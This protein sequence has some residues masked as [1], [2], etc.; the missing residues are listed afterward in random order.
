MCLCYLPVLHAREGMHLD[1]SCCQRVFFFCVTAFA[2]GHHSFVAR[3][4][5]RCGWGR[6]SASQAPHAHEGANLDHSCRQR[7]CGVNLCNQ[8]LSRTM[9]IKGNSA[10]LKERIWI[11]RVTNE[12]VFLTVA[13]LCTKCMSLQCER[14]RF[15]I[16]KS[17]CEMSQTVALE[18]PGDVVSPIFQECGLKLR[19]NWSTRCSLLFGRDSTHRPVR[20]REVGYIE[21]KRSS[22]EVCITLHH[23]VKHGRLFVAICR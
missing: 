13:L 11:Y 6:T 10:I 16:L 18:N 23:G 14:R 9:G 8:P 7:A 22:M 20:T 15:G 5:C 17:T 3:C 12:I 19:R 1:Y 21:S 4:E 2:I